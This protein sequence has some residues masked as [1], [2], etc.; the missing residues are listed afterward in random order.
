M[1]SSNVPIQKN[2][3]LVGAGNA[4]LRFL[5]MFGMR[6]LPGLAVTLISEAPVIPYSAMVPGHIAGDYSWEEITIDLVRLCRRVNI[7][8]VSAR[9]TGLDATKRK[10]VFDTRPEMS[11]DVLPGTGLARRT[12]GVADPFGLILA[13]AA[14]GRTDRAL[15]QPGGSTAALAPAVSSD[16][17]RRRCERL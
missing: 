6:P 3:V 13:D 15:E 7:R 10:V 9:A 8:F 16:C 1:L 5:K 12:A 2:V 4:H 17:R 11:D 14:P